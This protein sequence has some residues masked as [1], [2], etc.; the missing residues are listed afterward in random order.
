MRYSLVVLTH[1]DCA[2]L[3]ATLL[4]FATH[5]TPRPAS[6]VLLYDGPQLYGHGTPHPK[7][8]PVSDHPWLIATTERQR[9]FC[10][11]TRIAW[12]LAIGHNPGEEHEHVFYLEHDFLFERPVDLRDVAQV[13]DS[14]QRLC[15]MQFMRD[16]VS[17]EERA[18]GGLHALRRAGYEPVEAFLP[19]PSGQPLRWLEHQM[20]FSTNPSLM[21]RDWMEAHPWPSYPR[22]C[23]GRFGL[24][25]VAAGHRFGVWGQG[26]AW[27]RH[28]G[29]RTG[30]GY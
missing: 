24:D 6:C 5:V 28:A 16:A 26:E 2:P 21:R 10:E 12:S 17:E 29:V 7:L 20:Y 8:A 19:G 11:A 9:G 13:L 27:V 25:L 3:E 30:F 15:Q 23:E 4:S 14:N 18:A 22:E 1:G